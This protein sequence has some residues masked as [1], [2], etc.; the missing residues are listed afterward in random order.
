M[1]LTTRLRS[2]LSDARERAG[3][4]GETDGIAESSGGRPRGATG[5]RSSP[6]TKLFECDTCNDVYVAVE[7]ST[8]STCGNAVEQV[9]SSLSRE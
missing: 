8:C 7:K 1:T 9:P 3:R 6:E 4:D 5:S 2:V